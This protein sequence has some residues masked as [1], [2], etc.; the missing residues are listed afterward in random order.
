VEIVSNEQNAVLLEDEVA[1]L[2]GKWF[3]CGKF[4]WKSESRV[5]EHELCI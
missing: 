1:V 4:S 5:H 3:E 2:R